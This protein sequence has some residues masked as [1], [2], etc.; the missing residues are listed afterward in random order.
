MM[1]A[2]SGVS[3]TCGM[4]RPSVSGGAV[5]LPGSIARMYSPSSEA[6]RRSIWAFSK[7]STR[8]SIVISTRACAPSSSIESM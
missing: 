1:S 8:S 3:V 2:V 7:S 5:A 6:L 4:Q